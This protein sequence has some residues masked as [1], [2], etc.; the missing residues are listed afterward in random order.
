MNKPDLAG[1]EPARS[2]G[3]AGVRPGYGARR[4]NAPED[5]GLESAIF[6][7]LPDGVCILDEFGRVRHCNLAFARLVKRPTAEVIGRNHVE[8]FYHLVDNPTD[9]P[10]IQVERSRQG[11]SGLI[12][13]EGRWYQVLANP[14]FDNRGD[15]AG[16][17]HV[18]SDVTS[19]K[20]TEGILNRTNKVLRILNLSNQILVRSADEAA[21][22]EGVCRTVVETGG[23]LLAWTG[24]TGEAGNGDLR[25]IA[26]AGH[27]GGD[28]A[29][30]IGG[31]DEPA[32]PESLAVSAMKA[33]RPAILR[34]FEPS[35]GFR[36]S[37][38]S[39]APGPAAAS[40]VL[41]LTTNGSTLGVMAV[42]A[43]E[44]DAFTER[45][46]EMLTE[47]AADMA[48]G[49]AAIRTRRKH[50]QAVRDLQLSEEKYATL[51]EKGNDGIV[52]V[53][54]EKLTFVNSRAAD[55]LARPISDLIGASLAGVIAPDYLE[56]ALTKN[57]ARLQG[58]PVGGSYE[59]DLI[60]GNGGR[61]T[62]EISATIIDFQ[63][64]PATMAFVRDITERKKNG[65][66]LVESEKR[67]REAYLR[68]RDVQE[69]MIGAIATM[70]EMRDPYT[71][72]HQRRVAR[73]ACAIAA[74][75]GL[76]EDR[77]AGLAT[78]GLLHDIGKVQIPSDIL[79]KPGRL[80]AI[81]FEMI[82]SHS[83][84]GYQI[85]KSIPFPWP[86]ADM[87][88]QHHERLD[89]SGYP[90]GLAGER[91]ILEARILGV[92]DVIEA[93]ASHRPY[94]AA[95]GIDAALEEISKN[96]GKLFD[97]DVVAACLK[98]FSRGFKL[99]GETV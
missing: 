7:H 97:P 11:G 98:I 54:D 41:P 29:D 15:A 56:L 19:L 61:M 77:I 3:M 36:P 63:G 8:L 47:L 76:A 60:T 31:R 30:L 95:L 49:V 4:E 27:D 71:S 81:E 75:M 58:K 62:V 50:D 82:K 44:H 79:I 51:V 33:G 99:D 39:E 73:L 48:Y 12:R 28:L 90:A 46:V 53:Q 21:L 10:I 93:M 92:A 91:I 42:C 23:F 35:P 43:R 38:L 78:G 32:G 67:L 94:R 18:F 85:L 20:Q 14:L 68:L 37:T 74:E 55:I 34:S 25:E 83:Q 5:G 24:L 1:E 9:C 6:D 13:I 45:E 84:A 26:R 89:G 69:G 2:H 72:G 96:S 40:I 16:A 88:V 57:R 64:R 59:I 70:A 22:L 87:I 65:E 80:N 52:V 17:V 66:A 86:I